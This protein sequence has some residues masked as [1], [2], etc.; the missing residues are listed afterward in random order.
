MNFLIRPCS[1]LLSE[2][3]VKYLHT[4][5]I[6][7]R[8]YIWSW[9]SPEWVWNVKYDLLLPTEQSRLWS[10]LSDLV[11]TIQ[12]TLREKIGQQMEFGAHSDF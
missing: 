4:L 10:L 6:Q 1:V 7:I 3:S 8:K 5:Y 12:V 2:I 11:I 9:W